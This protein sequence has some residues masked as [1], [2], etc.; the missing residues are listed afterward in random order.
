M[1]D[2]IFLLYSRCVLLAVRRLAPFS[3]GGENF[4]PPFLWKGGD[5]MV[6]YAELFQYTLVIIGIV[7]LV[8]QC[9]KK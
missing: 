6:T 9:G 1:C 4:L 8:I 3:L 2:M 5:G 7:A